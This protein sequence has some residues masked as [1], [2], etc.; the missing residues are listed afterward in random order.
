M[1]ASH[2][3]SSEAFCSKF[4]GIDTNIMS[5]LLGWSLRKWKRSGMSNMIASSQSFSC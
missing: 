1:P 2:N 3:S 4:R 5:L